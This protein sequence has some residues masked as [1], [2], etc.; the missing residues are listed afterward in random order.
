MVLT[1]VK[2]IGEGRFQQMYEP[3]SFKFPFA[4]HCDDLL[5]ETSDTD[6]GL[7]IAQAGMLSFAQAKGNIDLTGRNTAQN[8]VSAKP[9]K[10]KKLHASK[11]LERFLRQKITILYIKILQGTYICALF[12]C[13]LF[14]VALVKISL[15]TF[16]K[17]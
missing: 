3:Q 10:Q 1:E 16:H 7:N 9:T 17:T 11:S 6:L 14:I 15:Y 4:N 5:D 12:F 8:D 2:H 13:P